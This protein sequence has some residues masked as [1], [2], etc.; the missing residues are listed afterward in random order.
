MEN[1]N[2]NALRRVIKVSM[3]PGTLKSTPDVQVPESELSRSSSFLP[4]FSMIRFQREKRGEQREDRNLWKTIWRVHLS[5]T[6][7]SGG[8]LLASFHRKMKFSARSSPILNEPA[9]NGK[10]RKP[11]TNRGLS[12]SRVFLRRAICQARAVLSR[13]KNL[14]SC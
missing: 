9:P 1:E 5:H 14:L 3:L 12:P 8:V 4:R 13:S 11:K 2:T 7:L 6:T 10:Q